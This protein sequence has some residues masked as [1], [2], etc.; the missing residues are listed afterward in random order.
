MSVHLDELQ[1]QMD[2]DQEIVFVSSQE[3][4]KD[5]NRKAQK[6]KNDIVHKIHYQANQ[7]RNEFL[8]KIA[9]LS[10]N[11]T[12]QPLGFEQLRTLK[13]Q[14]YS[15]V[16][17]KQDRQGCDNI[18]ERERFIKDIATATPHQSMKRTGYLGSNMNS[19]LLNRKTNS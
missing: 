18:P 14:I 2:T 8:E 11:K 3:N 7:K 19:K 6:A 17:I 15:T 13:L 5:I 1:K 10:M 12:R 9:A 16:G 4:I